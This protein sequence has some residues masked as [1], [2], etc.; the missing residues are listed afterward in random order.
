[1]ASGVRYTAGSKV[2]SP[3]GTRQSLSREWAHHRSIYTRNTTGI[4][5]WL[6]PLHIL[7]QWP[8][9]PTTIHCSTI[10]GRH[11]RLPDY[12]IWG[13][14]R[15]PPGRPRQTLT[16]G[17]RLVHAVPSSKMYSP[18]RH[19]QAEPHSDRVHHSRTITC[20]SDISQVPGGYHHRQGELEPTHRFHHKK[21]E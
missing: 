9:R 14:C 2:A 12:N 3:E 13:W 4:N 5:T 21:G 7:H 20:S 8:P 10:C 18:H 11:Y 6:I 19:Q 1:M 15:T 17:R 16:M